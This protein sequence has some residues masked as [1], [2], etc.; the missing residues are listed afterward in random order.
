[1]ENTFNSHQYLGKFKYEPGCKKTLS[2]GLKNL[3]SNCEPINL[4]L[5]KGKEINTKIFFELAYRLQAYSYMHICFS[6]QYD[7]RAFD[8]HPTQNT[9]GFV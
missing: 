6:V 8:M 2:R 4:L 1:M 7:F 9:F 3:E 5:F